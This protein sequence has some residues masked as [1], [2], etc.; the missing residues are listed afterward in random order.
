MCPIEMADDTGNPPNAQ[1]DAAGARAL[2][3]QLEAAIAS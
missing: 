1:W 3:D 2:R